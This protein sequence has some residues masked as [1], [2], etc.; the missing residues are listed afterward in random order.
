MAKNT[1]SLVLTILG[2]PTIL[3]QIQ[4]ARAISPPGMMMGMVGIGLG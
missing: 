4:H 2:V 3:G 1:T